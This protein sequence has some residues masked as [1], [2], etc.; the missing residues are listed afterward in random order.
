MDE[1]LAPFR[2]VMGIVFGT[3]RQNELLMDP[4]F[5]LHETDRLDRCIQVACAIHNYNLE[6]CRMWRSET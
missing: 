4:T 1:R 3:L 2:A 6:K 5:V